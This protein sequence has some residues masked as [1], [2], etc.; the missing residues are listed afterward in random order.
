CWFIWSILQIANSNASFAGWIRE[1]HASALLPLLLVPL[2]FLVFT[3]AKYL[4][5]FLIFIFAFSVLAALNGIK[6]LH[7]G[8]SP[9]EQQ[10]LDE[11]G[12]ITHVLFGRLRVF[13]FYSDAGQFG[14]SQAQMALMALILAFG[15]F[16]I[17]KRGLL[18]LAA[19][20]LLYGMLISGTRGALFALL[21][22]GAVA[23]ALWGNIRVII[24]GSF[25]L[26][27]FFCFLKFTYIGNGNYAIYRLRSA[28]NPEDPSLNLRFRTQNE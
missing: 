7:F 6:Q 3:R 21:V 27:S 11:G 20:L 2:G 10:F 1:V 14:A 24:V 19:A 23:V 26:V 16:R 5:Y 4:D 15:P 25:L 13:S 9:G 22:G 8:P 17:W 18:L 12:H 28:V